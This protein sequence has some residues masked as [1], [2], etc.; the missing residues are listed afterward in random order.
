M[1]ETYNQ[2]LIT[3]VKKHGALFV[4]F[5][6]TIYYFYNI[7]EEGRKQDRERLVKLEEKVEDLQNKYNNY[8]ENDNK[9]MNEQI[10]KNNELLQK[11]YEK[12]K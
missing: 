7:T 12:F 6:I 1:S 10:Y 2:F 11:V 9:R 8:I 4:F 5:L 3:Q